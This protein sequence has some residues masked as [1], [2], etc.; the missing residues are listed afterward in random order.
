[1][2]DVGILSTQLVLNGEAEDRS[3]MIRCFLEG[4]IRN[5][6]STTCSDFYFYQTNLIGSGLCLFLYAL[7]AMRSIEKHWFSHNV[8]DLG[9][10]LFRI[11]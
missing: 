3:Q 9:S 10:V 5:C 6:S 8:A 11:V 7:C 1:M 2:L 4:C